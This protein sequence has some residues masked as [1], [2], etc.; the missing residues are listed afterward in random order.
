MLIAVKSF[1]ARRHT[2]H[3]VHSHS[4]CSWAECHAG[5]RVRGPAAAGAPDCSHVAGHVCTR[6][7]TSRGIPNYVKPS[8]VVAGAVAERWDTNATL[9]TNYRKM[10]ANP[11][12]PGPLTHC[13]VAGLVSNLKTLK[14]TKKVH[15]RVVVDPIGAIT[16]LGSANKRS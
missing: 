12:S 11:P 16:S 4:S 10:G 15:E 2:P 3:L 13:L 9:T 5:T 8:A 7:A 14:A 1:K 6:K